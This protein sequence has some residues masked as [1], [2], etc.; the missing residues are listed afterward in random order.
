MSARGKRERETWCVTEGGDGLID[1]RPELVAVR[2]L[3]WLMTGKVKT[4]MTV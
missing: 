4:S 1:A 3:V 2:A